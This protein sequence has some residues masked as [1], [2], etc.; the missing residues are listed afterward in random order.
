[1][2]LINTRVVFSA[3]LFFVGVHAG[4]QQP[5]E[6]WTPQQLLEPSSLAAN[7]KSGKKMPL[8]FSV[9]PGAVIPGSIEIGMAK[10]KQNLQKLKQQ[11][12]KV[13]KDNPIVIYCGCC[14]FERCP[15]V[16]P[17]IQMLKD[18]KFTHYQLLNLPHNMKQ[19]WI[20]KGYPQIKT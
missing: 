3:L 16:R 20:D 12:K 5:K 17:A 2:K 13:S 1:M 9:G 15:N 18:L 4:A 11:L 19:D 8:I 6:N 10:E 7:L 14:P